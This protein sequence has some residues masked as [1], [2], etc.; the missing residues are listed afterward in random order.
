MI[1]YNVTLHVEEEIKNDWLEWMEKVH[2]PEVMA[3][4]K[5]VSFALYKIQ[6]HEPEDRTNNYTVQYHAN[7]IED[8]EDYV[9]NYGPGLKKKTM[10]RYGSK[11]IAFRTILDKLL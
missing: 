5:F 9:K 7:S 10:E 2:L 4:G 3:T 11:V 1:L 8:Y 6:N